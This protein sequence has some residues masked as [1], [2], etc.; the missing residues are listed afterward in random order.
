MPH[1]QC[2]RFI[3]FTTYFSINSIQVGQYS[4]ALFHSGSAEQNSTLHRTEFFSA[5]V[6]DLLALYGIVHQSSCVYTPQQIGTVERKHRH[7]LEV[8]RALK[9]QSSLPIHFW[10]ECVRTAVNLINK[11]PTEVLGGRSPYEMLHQKTPG[12]DHLRVFGCLCYATTR[13][14]RG[15]EFA[16]RARKSVFLGYSE[17]QNGYRLYDII[18]KTFFVS[19]DVVF[20]ENI[21]P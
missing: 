5:S 7:I 3:T 11:L 20:R 15:D 17:V 19:R 10:G 18:E 21:F 13:L 1:S 8:A 14:P 6:V 12:I 16:P 4:W 9:F 2:N